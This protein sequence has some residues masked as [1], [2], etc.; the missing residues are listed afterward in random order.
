MPKPTW[1]IKGQHFANCNCAYGCPCQFN[2]LPTDGTCKAIIAWDIEEGYFG[3]TPLN[4]LKLAATYAWENPIHEGNGEM[5]VIVEEKASEDQRKAL[6]AL[7][8]GEDAEPGMTMIKIYRS[9]CTKVHDPIFAPIQM[10][11]NMEERTASIKVDGVIESTLE[12]IKNPVTGVAHRAS[13]NFP[14]GKEFQR[15]E[16]A[17]GTTK[18]TGAVALSF[19]S[20]HAHISSDAMTSIG[21]NKAE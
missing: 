4:G 8:N 5:Q 20:R 11:I 16:V 12:P 18:G 6:I 21:P 14:N 9:M 17:S 2:A 13:V 1:V 7:M 3:N 19:A 15:A 10:N